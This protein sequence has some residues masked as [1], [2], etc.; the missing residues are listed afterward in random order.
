MQQ[1][2]YNTLSA[3]EKIRL[4]N[5]RAK[6]FSV[7]AQTD[8]LDRQGLDKDV[9]TPD[10]LWEDIKSNPDLYGSVQADWNVFGLQDLGEGL[11]GVSD[12]IDSTS[13]A[14]DVA[15]QFVTILESAI[16][17]ALT[18]AIEG[19]NILREAFT[20]AILALESFI[21]LFASTRVAALTSRHMTIKTSKSLPDSLIEISNSYQDQADRFRPISR[22]VSD[23]HL[24]IGFFATA[25]SISKL[26]E[27]FSVLLAL[28]PDS[29]KF[30]FNNIDTYN[31][32]ES[33]PNSMFTAGSATAPNWSSLSLNDIEPFKKTINGLIVAVNALKVAISV[34]DAMS[35]QIALVKKRI[36][37]ID[38]SLKLAIT[39]LQGFIEIA[40]SPIQNLLVY[41]TGDIESV[42]STISKA[43]SLSTYPL[44]PDVPLEKTAYFAL[45]FVLGAGRALDVLRAAFKINDLAEDLEWGDRIK[46]NSDARALAQTNAAISSTDINYVWRVKGD[47]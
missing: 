35:R 5:I 47:T 6:R 29:Q 12:I 27:A 43:S 21:D 17:L 26:T 32:I 19:A 11:E 28:M 37:V 15:K 8:D 31:A 40:E 39:A 10:Q 46:E 2:D 1:R 23:V 20:I 13:T 3:E 34:T 16:D 42:Y 14:L 30:L 9:R 41:G 44:N 38:R 18:L 24:F 7:G 4:A 33:Y 22:S 25:P 36:E 45:H